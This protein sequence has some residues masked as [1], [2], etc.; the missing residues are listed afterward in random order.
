MLT[1]RYKPSFVRAF[2]KLPEAL[3]SEALER[4]EQ[5]KNPTH[6][7]SLRVHKLKGKLKGFYSFSVTYSHRVVFQY[8][9]RDTVALL[10]IGDHAVYR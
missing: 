1:L 4:L 8:E 6:H 7:Q 10:A 3:Q 9:S 2:A 5:F